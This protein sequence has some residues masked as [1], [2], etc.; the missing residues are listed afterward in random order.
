MILMLLLKYSLV[1]PYEKKKAFLL[2]DRVAFIIDIPFA[3][4]FP[5]TP[6]YEVPTK[7]FERL[8]HQELLEVMNMPAFWADN[9]MFSKIS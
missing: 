8:T 3:D 6:I 9:I 2:S 4:G 5:S 7:K 1:F